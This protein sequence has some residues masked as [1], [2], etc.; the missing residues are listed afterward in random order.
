MSVAIPS[1][2]WVDAARRGLGDLVRLSVHYLNTEAELDRAA[3]VIG[4]L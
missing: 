2:T 1:S 3:D 4:D